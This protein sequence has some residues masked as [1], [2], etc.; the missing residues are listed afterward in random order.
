MESNK[1]T[2][3]LIVELR[4]KNGKLSACDQIEVCCSYLKEGID[5]QARLKPYTGY[6]TT[7]NQNRRN[8]EH[9]LSVVR[10]EIKKQEDRLA[11]LEAV[12]KE[13]Y[14]SLGYCGEHLTEKGIMFHVRPVREKPQALQHKEAK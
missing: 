11:E 2:A 7:V 12:I 1:P 14:D 3:E 9:Y 5:Q 4:E 13:A 6:V 8:I 10:G